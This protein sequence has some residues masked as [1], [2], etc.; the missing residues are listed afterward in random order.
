MT[1]SIS[2]NNIIYLGLLG[3]INYKYEIAGN[4]VFDSFIV[5]I[6]TSKASLYSIHIPL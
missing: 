2:V 6:W 3:C 5:E 1:I 4:L